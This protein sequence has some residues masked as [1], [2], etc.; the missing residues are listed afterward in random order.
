M[1]PDFLFRTHPRKEEAPAWAKA[2]CQGMG[3]VLENQDEIMGQIED[4][5]DGSSRL[6]AK[7][8]RLLE[9]YEAQQSRPE[10]VMQE[11]DM[12]DTLSELNDM[13]AKV[14]SIIDRMTAASQPSEPPADE[15]PA[16]TSAPPADPLTPDVTPTTGAAPSSQPAA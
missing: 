11:P 16:S 4:I 10:P 7:I 9:L 15:T 1:L 12:S 5:K 3:L 13:D 8:D 2:L 6:N 14:E